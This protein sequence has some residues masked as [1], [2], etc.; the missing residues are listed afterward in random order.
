MFNEN[1]GI[2]LNFIE[3]GVS[4]MN[5]LQYLEKAREKVLK[6]ASDIY[7]YIDSDLSQK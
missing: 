5:C 7:L 3:E 2:N 4:E 1:R 6:N